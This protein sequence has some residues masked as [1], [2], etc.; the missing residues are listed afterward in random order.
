MMMVM[1]MMM[2]MMM[3]M[4]RMFRVDAMKTSA[5]MSGCCRL[6]SYLSTE[7]SLYGFAYNFS[8]FFKLS[9]LLIEL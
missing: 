4:K 2:M 7:L 8:S 6:Q 1:M 9:L 3:M 5:L